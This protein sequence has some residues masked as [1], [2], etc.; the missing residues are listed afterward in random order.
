[1]KKQEIRYK[2]KIKR[3]YFQGVRRDFC[4]DVIAENFM[5][6][7][8][9]FDS[10]LLYSAIGDEAKT[11]IIAEKLLKLG[12]SV[13]FPR[14]EGENIVPV[15][16]GQMKKGAFGILEPVGQAY[17]DKIDV[18]VVPLLAVNE[19]GFRV[20][21][22]KGFYDRYLKTAQTKSV[23]LGYSFQLDEFEEDEWDEPLD[24]FICE[25]GVFKFGRE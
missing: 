17:T 9:H 19:R 4:D 8:G 1:M 5:A 22:G 10:F 15:L 18:T 7:Y 21:Y 23:G 13:F 6:A 11:S 14:V 24:E 3:R 25:K 12:K 2:L 20:G 16:C